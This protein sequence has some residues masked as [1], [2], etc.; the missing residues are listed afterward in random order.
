MKR[1][2][3]VE[4]ICFFL[5]MLFV[6]TAINKVIDF[7]R[8]RAQIG[9]SPMLTAFAKPLAVL[10]ASIELIISILLTLPKFRLIALYGALS[11]MT[12][13]T[14]Y[15]II[16]L[17]FSPFVPCSCGGV[18]E[19]LSWNQHLVFNMAFLL[20]ALLGIVIQ[21]SI[22]NDSNLYSKTV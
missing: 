6:Y 10:V 2:I 8:F 5:I 22:S 7:E 1:R 20:M 9:Q 3:S 18:L 12:M 14:A 16:I 21:S 17:N 11:L 15:I 13:F 19:V 4:V